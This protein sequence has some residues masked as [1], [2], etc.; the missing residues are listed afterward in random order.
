MPALRRW[1]STPLAP[2]AWADR[3]ITAYGCH[4]P[5]DSIFDMADASQRG[6]LRRDLPADAT[7]RLRFSV[8]RLGIVCRWGSVTIV[9]DGV[10]TSAVEIAVDDSSSVRRRLLPDAV[11]IRRVVG[12][13]DAAGP[14]LLS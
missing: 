6:V 7:L 12:V 3:L 2:G 4:R 9:G 1:P 8:R 10:G 14:Q 13:L 11:A 5:A